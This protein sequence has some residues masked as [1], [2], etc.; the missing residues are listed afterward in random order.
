VSRTSPLRAW[1]FCDV[2]GSKPLRH[3]KVWSSGH[4]LQQVGRFELQRL[5]TSTGPPPAYFWV[6]VGLTGVATVVGTSA[7]LMA[8]NAHEQGRERAALYLDT[9]AEAE[10]TRHLALASDVGFG[11]AVLFGA[12]ATVLYFV[13]DWP[14]PEGHARPGREPS[15]PRTPAAHRWCGAR[16][17]S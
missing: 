8:L 14:K 17:A 16:A 5:S 10:R 6:A 3:V 1:N 9:A 4:L 12:T 15:A 7:G 2:D 11:A 13:T